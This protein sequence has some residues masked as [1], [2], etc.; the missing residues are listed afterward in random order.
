MNFPR[1]YFALNLSFARR[2]AEVSGVSLAEALLRYTQLYLAFEL[3]RDFNSDHPFW[4]EYLAGLPL[5]TDVDEY[6][7]QV[8]CRALSERP[9][10]PPEF[11][12]GCFTYAVWTGSRVRLHFFNNQP[13]LSP[14]RHELISERT[15]ELKA[16][17]AHVRANLPQAASVVGGSWLYNIEAYQRL[18]PPEFTRSAV[19]E[20]PP[21][22]QFLA[23]WGQFLDMTAPAA[24]FAEEAGYAHYRALDGGRFLAYWK[25]DNEC[26][27]A[28]LV[29]R[30][31][32]YLSAPWA[33][34][35]IQNVACQRPLNPLSA[36]PTSSYYAEEYLAAASCPEDYLIDALGNATTR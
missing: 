14:L 35:R 10:Q 32:V 11:A 4:Q 23:L 31:N 9:R 5:A 21:E 1:E 26:T 28:T 13:G 33:C 22:P 17:F 29:M 19:L 24:R 25:T 20:D 2:A 36:D 30:P 15:A 34:A 8:Y 27:Q 3:G 6:T 12:F 16:L 18:F 7:R